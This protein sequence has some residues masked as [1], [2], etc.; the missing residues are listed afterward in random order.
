MMSA[1]MASEKQQQKLSPAVDNPPNG[2]QGD[3]TVTDRTERT[4]PVTVSVMKTLEAGVFWL[5]RDTHTTC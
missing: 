5:Y 3:E 2:G 4:D 1:G